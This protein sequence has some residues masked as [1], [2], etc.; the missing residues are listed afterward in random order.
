V[1]WSRLWLRL[2][3]EEAEQVHEHERPRRRRA[4]SRS[5]AVPGRGSQRERE[6][7]QNGRHVS[8]AEIAAEVPVHLLERDAQKSV[9]SSRPPV[10]REL[11]TVRVAATEPRSR[12]A[13]QELCQLLDARRARSYVAPLLPRAAGPS[14]LPARHCSCSSIEQRRAD[15][16]DVVGAPQRRPA[17]GVAHELRGRARRAGRRRARAA[18]A[19]R[20]SK[21]FGEDAAP[22]A[23]GLRNSAAGARPSRAGG[24]ATRGAAR[25]RIQLDAIGEAEAF[26]E[27]GGRLAEKSPRKRTVTSSRT[28]GGERSEERLRVAFC[29][30]NEPACVK[31][32]KRSPRV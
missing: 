8:D 12:E 32:E 6:Q 2:D 19:A 13:L 7:E 28:G 5:C 11:A 14:R 4:R 16:V 21:T 24:A 22:A 25:A 18:S 1:N 17:P 31:P 23:A 26:H 10:T 20:Y 9:A 29:R 15:A 30:K 3:V 27:L